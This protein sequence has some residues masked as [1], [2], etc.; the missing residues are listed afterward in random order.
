MYCSKP[1]T[2]NL[3][4]FLEI[5][6][7]KNAICSYKYSI[8]YIKLLGRDVTWI[9][10][11][12]C[13]PV[14]FLGRCKPVLCFATRYV[15]DLLLSPSYSFAMGHCKHSEWNIGFFFWKNLNEILLAP[16][17]SPTLS[18]NQTLHTCNCIN[19]D[20]SALPKGSPSSNAELKK[21]TRTLA[22]RPWLRTRRWRQMA[23]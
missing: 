17:F 15:F 5:D 11:D 8:N 7:W 13:K 18:T 3:R 9:I 1:S 10:V 19:H 22:R 2:L 16:W 21:N 4:I 14:V 12:A 20:A 23:K 6:F